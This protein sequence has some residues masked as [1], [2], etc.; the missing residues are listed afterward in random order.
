MSGIKKLKIEK[1]LIA[2]LGI[3][4]LVNVGF[5]GVSLAKYVD[6]KNE[7]SSAE[8]LGFAPVFTAGENWDEESFAVTASSSFHQF[9]VENEGQSDVNV[10]VR[11]T[12]GDVLPLTAELYGVNADQVE[13]TA[14]ITPQA[15]DDPKVLTYIVPVSAD[16]T[17]QFT[18]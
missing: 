4:L 15:S 17:A 3:L 11:V 10:V 6:V 8:T 18:L 1:M 5:I 7:G 14:P 12:L 2:L 16:G 9:K 13:G